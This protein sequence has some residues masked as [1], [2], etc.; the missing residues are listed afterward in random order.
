MLFFENCKPPPAIR[1]L[2]RTKDPPRRQR[3]RILLQVHPAVARNLLLFLGGD[4]LDLI[5][6]EPKR[7]EAAGCCGADA[8]AMFSDAAGEDE[9]IHSAQQCHV[10]T[11]RFSDS[12]RKNI[13]GKTGL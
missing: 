1:N 8:V 7:F 12:N 9:K 11:N 4:N 13:Q 5:W 10:R 2:P 6:G 3:G